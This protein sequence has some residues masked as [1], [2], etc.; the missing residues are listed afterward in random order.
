MLTQKDNTKKEGNDDHKRFELTLLI[1][2][3]IKSDLDRF[4]KRQDTYDSRI[5]VVFVTTSSAALYFI[6]NSD[7]PSDW[8]FYFCLAH[9]VFVILFNQ[10][11]L[12]WFHYQ[13]T[14]LIKTLNDSIVKIGLNKLEASDDEIDSIF[15]LTE[16]N[17]TFQ[18]LIRDKE[19]IENRGPKLWRFIVSKNTLIQLVVWSIGILGMINYF[20]HYN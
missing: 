18:D 2:E 20:I 6:L 13:Y 15:L 10:T 3:L 9:F 12:V 7:Y 1:K 11:M 4:V 19:D 17:E 14:K 8:L 16:A 5:D